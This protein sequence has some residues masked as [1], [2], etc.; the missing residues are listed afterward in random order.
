MQQ[1][2]HST[3]KAVKAVKIVDFETKSVK[4]IKLYIY[5]Y[6]LSHLSAKAAL[7]SSH[8]IHSFQHI[9]KIFFT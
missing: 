5:I 9:V 7:L 2:G 6:I 4:A 1:G 8:N 3:A